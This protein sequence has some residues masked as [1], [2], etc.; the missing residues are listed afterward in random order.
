MHSLLIAFVVF[1][2]LFG[3]AQLGLLLRARLPPEHLSSDSKDV[4]KL[5]MGLVATMAALVLGLLTASAKGSFDT[6]SSEIQQSAAHIILL[7]RALA[8]YGS[9]T[10]AIR[11]VVR[12]AVALRLELT[13]PEDGASP[14]PLASTDGPATL[15]A[16]ELGIR[17]LAPRSD[18][19]REQQSRALSITND[20]SATR[21]LVFAQASNTLPLPFL[22][23]LVFWLAL[24]FT[25]FGLFAPRNATVVAALLLCALAVSGS[26]FLIL[27]MSRPLEG[28]I[29]ISNAPLRYALSQLGR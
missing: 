20:L 15:E 21:W 24:L 4:V 22:V 1:A 14:A 27:E 13:W 11:D 18:A 17:A 23:V 26:T 5:A 16:I 12:R 6:Q 8:Q 7:D 25:S 28:L 3:A 2:C 19:Q 10:G 9:E 29:K